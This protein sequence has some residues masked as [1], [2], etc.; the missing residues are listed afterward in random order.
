MRRRRFHPV[1][2][3][4]WLGAAAAIAALLAPWVRADRY[5]GRIEKALEEALGRK[6]DITGP[7]RFQLWPGPGFSA[8]NVV[9]HDDPAMGAEPLAYVGTLSLSVRPSALWR[10]RL[11]VATLRLGEPSVNL[12]KSGPR[13]WNFPWLLERAFR[14]PAR[15]SDSV[16]AIHV[17]SGRLNFK[18]GDTKSVFYLAQ[19]DLDINPDV[20]A[21]AVRIRF[22]GLMAR[23]DRPPF[24]AGRL[25][26]RGRLLVVPEQ[27][28]QLDLNLHL[29]RSAIAE[30]LV[31]LQGRSLGL[32]GFLS[33]TAR[34][35]G[36][37]SNLAIRGNLHLAEVSRGILPFGPERGSIDY[38]GRLE[39]SAQN[40]LLESRPGPG[41]TVPAWIRFRLSSYL[42][43]PRWAIGV[44]V[45]RLPVDSLPALARQLGASLPAGMVLKGSAS[46]AM[47]WSSAAGPQGQ[48]QVENGEV[49]WTEAD[50]ASIRFPAARIL[51]LRDRLRMPPTEFRMSETEGLRLELNAG[52]SVERL[53]LRLHCEALSIG[54]FLDV[55]NRLG[56]GP[57]PALLAALASGRFEGSLRL[58][59]TEAAEG[60][61][62]GS[63]LVRDATWELP[64]FSSPLRLVAAGVVLGSGG[65]VRFLTA[66]AE[67]IAFGGEYRF[68]GKGPRPHRLLLRAER[69]D[70]SR[71]GDLFAPVLRRRR[72]FLAR[73][74]RLSPPPAPGW[75]RNRRVEGRLEIAHLEAGGLQLD[76]VQ[77]AFYWHGTHLELAGFRAV[78]RGAA[79]EGR[80]TAELGG[81]T[82]SARGRFAIGGMD[83]NGGSLSLDAGFAAQGAELMRPASLLVE[84]AFSGKSLDLGGQSWER[85]SGCFELALERGTARERL[86]CAELR[87]GEV[88]YYGYTTEAEGGRAELLLFRDGEELLLGGPLLFGKART[89]SGQAEQQSR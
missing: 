20:R 52:P 41:A 59:K 84:G 78:W 16:P 7:V 74:L 67:E 69:A 88:I 85:A 70:A 35:E 32:G 65:S 86:T 48:F 40:L 19:A 21:R 23:T 33:S 1:R 43:E 11:E 14:N 28:S 45:R 56:I 25:S 82:L 75:L 47:S 31:L 76:S 44:T 10:R 6:V 29:E 83:W 37:L 72:G 3:A 39:V 9:I 22:A 53:D 15:G 55:W 34:L 71:L 27:E 17:R 18:F 12:V 58:N 8:Q 38:G 50:T 5:R 87:R 51:L 64:G 80:L 77:T 13:G 26:G 73:T 63:G 62:E 68:V 49:G 54:R 36:P 4:A 2:T 24:G 79:V 89:E 46:G 60:T 81:A 61:W 57:P 30:I 42:T 66:R